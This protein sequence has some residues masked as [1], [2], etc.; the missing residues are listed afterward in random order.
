MG[1]S[2]TPT[3]PCATQ[4]ER[5]EKRL[6][7][8]EN[9]ISVLDRHWEQTE[10][11]AAALLARVQVAPPPLVIVCMHGSMG[12]W[13]PVRR[14]KCLGATCCRHTVTVPLL[15]VPSHL[16]RRGAPPAPRA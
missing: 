16:R 3:A 5:T 11:Q 12:R 14:P 9:A 1:A 2:F 7:T 13:A 8:K 10:Q 4:L 15:P 6:L